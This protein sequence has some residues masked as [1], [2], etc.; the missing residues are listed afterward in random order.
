MDLNTF[1]TLVDTRSTS[2]SP[3]T[4]NHDN[5]L[6]TQIRACFTL[7]E[8]DQARSD[9]GH[10]ID[11]LGLRYMC[12]RNIVDPYLGVAETIEEFFCHQFEFLSFDQFWINLA[13]LIPHC[14]VEITCFRAFW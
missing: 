8:S 10:M 2:S 7:K 13:F 12:E 5:A 1:K 3:K 4:N 14:I 11:D 9:I 6:L